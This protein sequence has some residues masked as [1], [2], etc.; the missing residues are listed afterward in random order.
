MAK[1]HLAEER[2]KKLREVQCFAH[3]HTAQEQQ[4][5]SEDEEPWPFPQ[6]TFFRAEQ[7]GGVM[8]LLLLGPREETYGHK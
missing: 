4:A 1:R 2:S 5:L 3:D 7:R 8:G 6:L